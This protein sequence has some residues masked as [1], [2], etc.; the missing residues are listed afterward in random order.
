VFVSKLR[1]DLGKT[2]SVKDIEFPLQLSAGLTLPLIIAPIS[3]PLHHSD[4]IAS[5]FSAEQDE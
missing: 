2:G 3:L 4:T 5:G 1:T